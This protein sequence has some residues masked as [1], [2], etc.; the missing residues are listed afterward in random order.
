MAVADVESL[1]FRRPDGS[2]VEWEVEMARVPVEETRKFRTRYASYRRFPLA[3]RYA[4][5]GEDAEFALENAIAT[6]LR[7]LRRFDADRALPWEENPRRY[8]WELSRLV[9]FDVDCESPFLIT[10]EFGSSLAGLRSTGTAG[11]LSSPDDLRAFASGLARGLVMLDR[12]GVVHRQVRANTVHWDARS[13]TVQ[14]NRFEYAQR[15]GEARRRLAPA[16]V[17]KPEERTARDW[18]AAEQILGG[19]LVDPRDDVFSVGCAIL[20]VT[21]RG[22]QLGPGGV[23]DVAASGVP[24]LADMLRG[25]FAPVAHR[26]N[27]AELLGRLGGSIAPQDLPQAEP[28]RL[29]EGRAEYDRITASKNPHWS[30]FASRP[31]PAEPPPPEPPSPALSESGAGAGPSATAG[32]PQPG[33]RARRPRRGRR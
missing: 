20:S 6:G 25:V 31:M 3:I 16:H 29:V 24:F 10:V 30:A 15:V 32:S 4:I 14:I 22:L 33:R 8:P 18:E 7:M 9:G 11:V 13:R 19:G 1:S 28:D 26:P 21:A 17:R 12:L 27:A 23:P 2:R 5:G